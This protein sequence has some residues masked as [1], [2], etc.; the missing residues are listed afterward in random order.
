M[1]LIKYQNQVP[2]EHLNGP[3]L[4]FLNKRSMASDFKVSN[5]VWVLDMMFLVGLQFT[6]I[7]V[8]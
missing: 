7:D 3:G 4:A 5:P 6:F 1:V 8:Q 2:P